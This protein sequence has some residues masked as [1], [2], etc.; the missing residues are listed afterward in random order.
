MT[1]RISLQHIGSSSP[2]KVKNEDENHTSTCNS[3]LVKMEDQKLTALSVNT[4]PSCD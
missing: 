4:N 1:I 2:A 3:S